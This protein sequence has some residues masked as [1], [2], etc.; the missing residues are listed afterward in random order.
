[1]VAD[2]TEPD[3]GSEEVRREVPD[4]PA[5]EVV[6]PEPSRRLYP[7]TV[8][9]GFYLVILILATLAIVVSA[10]D[11]WRIGMRILA[12]TLAG[13]GTLRLVLRT[14][15]AGMLAVRHRALDVLLLGSVAVAL[16]VLAGSIPE[17]PRL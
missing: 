10:R 12:L 1:M 15:D 6:I 2:E 4:T 11:D 3:G 8:G 16:W 5:D 9:G 14:H 13:A 7:R 17:Q